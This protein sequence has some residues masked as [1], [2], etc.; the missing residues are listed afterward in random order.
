MLIAGSANPAARMEGPLARCHREGI[1]LQLSHRPPVAGRRCV[2]SGE[3]TSPPFGG[4]RLAHDGH[5]V[6]S[7][8]HPP[9]R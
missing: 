3:V 8:K 4:E 1:T 5:V 7:E 2:R 6:S 9:N